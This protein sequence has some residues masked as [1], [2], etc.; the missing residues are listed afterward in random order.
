MSLLC[1]PPGH[2]FG[3]IAKPFELLCPILKKPQKNIVKREFR[4]Q[5]ILISNNNQ[6]AGQV[7]SQ[8]M[9]LKYFQVRWL[10]W[11]HVYYGLWPLLWSLLS[12]WPVVALLAGISSNECLA[13][14]LF[15][16]KM[17]QWLKSL[18]IL[19]IRCRISITRQVFWKSSK[20]YFAKLN[21]G[22]STSNPGN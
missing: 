18:T 11:K 22:S 14:R 6:T 19:S 2:I 3:V 8:A 15:I 20:K 1:S 13:M 9:P 4:I 10:N 17:M 16:Y 5:W 21:S 12:G 7:G